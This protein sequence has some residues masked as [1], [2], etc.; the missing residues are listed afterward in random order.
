MNDEDCYSTVASCL[1][2]LIF[3]NEPMIV[4]LVPK[5][6]RI[7]LFCCS[8][9]LFVNGSE[10]LAV[11]WQVSGNFQDLCFF[12]SIFLSI[13]LIL[14][15]YILSSF[16]RLRNWSMP[17]YHVCVAIVK[18]DSHLGLCIDHCILLWSFLLPV[19]SG[20]LAGYV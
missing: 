14:S 19:S 9:V 5:S 17:I 8:H 6:S 13:H 12:P 15:N 16:D 3:I 1:V 11:T 18:F 4:N 2:A 20:L 10:K 7:L